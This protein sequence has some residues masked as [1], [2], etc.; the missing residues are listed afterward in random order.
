MRSV[1]GVWFAALALTTLLV[2]CADAAPRAAVRSS[3]SGPKRRKK[4]PKSI[5]VETLAVTEHGTKLEPFTYEEVSTLQKDH[6]EVVVHACCLTS[7]DVQQC[8][9]DWGPCL[10]PLVP[11]REAVG[12]VA[13]VGE[14]VKGLAVGDRVAVLLGTGLDSEADDDGADRSA[15]DLLTTG[16]AARRLRVP[17]RWAFELPMAL[18]SAQAAGLL[19]TGG[20]VWSQLTA[21]KLSKGSKVGVVGSGA[22]AALALQLAEALGMEAYAVSDGASFAALAHPPRAT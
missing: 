22:A 4:A 10:M 19:S 8:R 9:G 2:H 15:L 14:A 21:R 12:V 16:A 3:S 1:S 13:K 20:A 5:H 7:G 17:A 6:V 11:G 18:P